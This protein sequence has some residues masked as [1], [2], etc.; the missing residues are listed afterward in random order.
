M[1]AFESISMALT[2]FRSVQ[3]IKVSQPRT[4]RS[5]FLY[6][7]LEQGSSYFSAHV[8]FTTGRLGLLYFTYAPTALVQWPP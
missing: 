3:T 6:L 2:T 5:A 4:Q 8:L 7:V 1:C